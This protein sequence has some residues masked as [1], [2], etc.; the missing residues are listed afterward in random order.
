MVVY[1]EGYLLD[2]AFDRFRYFVLHKSVK[3][4]FVVRKALPFYPLQDG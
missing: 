4:P 1:A 2:A 3:G